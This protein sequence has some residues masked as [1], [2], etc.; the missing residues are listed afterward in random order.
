MA[1]MLNRYLVGL[2]IDAT[3][4]RGMFVIGDA[5]MPFEKDGAIADRRKLGADGIIFELVDVTDKRTK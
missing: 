3:P 1:K 4:V 5:V 2:A